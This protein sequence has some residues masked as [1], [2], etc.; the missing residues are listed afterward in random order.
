M[1]NSTYLYGKHMIFV[2]DN[3]QPFIGFSANIIL[4][5]LQLIWVSYKRGKMSESEWNSESGVKSH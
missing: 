5:K 4:T 3:G 2:K 1:N